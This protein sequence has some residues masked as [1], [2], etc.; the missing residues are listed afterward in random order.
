MPAD[1]DSK[2]P[3]IKVRR[4][5]RR[6]YETPDAPDEVPPGEVPSTS[7]TPTS[8]EAVDEVPPTSDEVPPTD[9]E[10]DADDAHEVPP[11]SVTARAAAAEALVKRYALGAAGIG[12]LPFPLA[13]TAALF[14]LQAHLLQALSR[15]YEVEYLE[16][17]SRIHIAS[18]MAAATPFPAGRTLWSLV[19]SVPVV[20]PVTGA[21]S[22]SAIAGAVTFA[23]GKVFV[24][25]FENGGSL[26][27]F[28]ARRVQGF[29]RQQ[30]DAARQW[31]R[32]RAAAS[33]S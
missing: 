2:S 32:T 10:A 6:L 1:K 21:L 23:L 26:I 5:R 28:D 24:R 18:L 29:F 25:H 9:A 30:I 13:D 27:D 16:K 14:A 12:L 20:G 33:D 8:D 17:R 3:R 7:V 22:M 31:K 15:L 11:T 4:K 19:K